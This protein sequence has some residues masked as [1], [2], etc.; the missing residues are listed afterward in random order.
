MP[1]AKKSIPPAGAV[2]PRVNRSNIKNLQS[3]P[4]FS[5]IIGI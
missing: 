5:K 2:R 3:K 4:L 1:Q